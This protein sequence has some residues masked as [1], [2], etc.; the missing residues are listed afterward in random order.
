M[1]RLRPT[2]ARRAHDRLAHA[3]GLASG[4]RDSPRRYVLQHGTAHALAVGQPLRAVEWLTDFAWLQ[5]RT[6]GNVAALGA[7]RRSC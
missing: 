6:G 3:T 2:Y 4:L 1:A 5:L 7:P